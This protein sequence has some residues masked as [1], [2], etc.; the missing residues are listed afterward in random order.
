MSAPQEVA[1]PP[2]LAAWFVDLFAPDGEAEPISGDLFEE[3]SAIASGKGT[4][5]ARSWYWK[6]SLKSTAHLFGTALR[7]APWLIAFTTLAGFFILWYARNVLNLPTHLVSAVIDHYSGFY[8]AHFSGWQLCLNYG[9]P[10]VGWAFAVVVGCLIAVVAKGREIVATATF[11]IFQFL[12]ANILASLLFLFIQEVLLGRHL[13]LSNTGYIR[14]TIPVIYH[15]GGIGALALFF[16]SPFTTVLAPVLGGLIVRKTRS[17][18]TQ[19][20]PVVN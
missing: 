7:S 19:S 2:R 10:A 11:G 17:A 13:I 3:F 16:I 12:L 15:Y 20:H 9:I 1:Q 18:A 8:A 14:I 5:A 6:Q 4:S